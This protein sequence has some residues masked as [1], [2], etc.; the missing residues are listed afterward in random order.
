MRWRE[1]AE[2]RRG[3]KSRS[4]EALDFE[5]VTTVTPKESTLRAEGKTERDKG[6]LV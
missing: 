1:S 5:Y 2:A 4:I 3:Q 6:N